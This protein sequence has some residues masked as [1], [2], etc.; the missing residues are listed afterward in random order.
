MTDGFPPVE[1]VS[2]GGFYRCELD[3]DDRPGHGLISIF[4]QIEDDE[5][6]DMP[7]LFEV[8]EYDSLDNLIAGHRR[9]EQT[10]TLE[11]TFDTP[12]FDVRIACS[13]ESTVVTV[14]LNSERIESAP[15]PSRVR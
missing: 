1:Y 8:I 3:G 2:E 13:T 6:V 12:L 4:E 9:R 7:L 11:L 15:E 10:S 14:G 5:A